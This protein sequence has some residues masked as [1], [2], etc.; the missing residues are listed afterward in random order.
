VQIAL[1][2]PVSLLDSGGQT[3]PL[4]GP[5]QRAVLAMLA[6]NVGH[7]VSVDRLIREIWQ[8][9]PPAAAAQGLQSYVS[10]LRRILSADAPGRVARSPASIRSRPPG[11]LLEMNADDIDAVRFTRLMTEGRALLTAQRPRAAHLRL[12]AALDLWRGPVLAD[13]DTSSFAVAE[14][15]R[16]EELRL[17]ALD[18]LLEVQLAL[19]DAVGC[20]STAR[21]VVQE[22]PY[23]ERAWKSLVLALYRDSRQAEALQT[24]SRMRELLADEL[25]IDP[26][27]ELA[28][29]HDQLLQQDPALQ[30]RPAPETD[31][32][33]AQPTD[34]VSARHQAESGIQL[35]LAP[36]ARAAPAT[37]LGRDREVD[38]LGVEAAH[39]ISGGT[40]TL[41]IQGAAGMGKSSLL[42]TLSNQV[43]D[44]GGRVARAAGAEGRAAPALWPWVMIARLLTDLGGPHSLELLAAPEGIPLSQLQLAGPTLDPSG[45]AGDP[46]LAR[47]LLFRAVID[48]VHAAALD[49]PLL[50]ALDDGHWLDEQSAQLLGLLVSEISAPRLLIA[51][52][53]RTEEIKAGTTL[54]QVLDTLTR[55]ATTV[56]RLKGL[57]V[58]DVAELT[59]NVSGGPCTPALAAAMAKRTDGNPL[60]VRE[61]SALLVSEQRLTEN[62][63]ASALPVGIQQIIRQRLDRLPVQTV[64]VLSAAAVLGPHIDLRVLGKMTSLDAESLLE[65]CETALLAGLLVEDSRSEGILALSHDL[66]RQTLYE[67]ISAPRRLRLHALAAEALGVLGRLRPETEVE[68]ARHLT[69]AAP[70]IGG[71][72]AV[73]ALLQVADDA[74]SKYAIDDVRHELGTALDLLKYIS[75]PAS[76]TRQ[77]VLIRTRLGTLAVLTQGLSHRSAAEQFEQVLDLAGTAPLDSMTN[78][79]WFGVSLAMWTRAEFDLPLRSAQAVLAAA[80]TDDETTVAAHYTCGMITFLLGRRQEAH[81]HFTGAYEL[82]ESGTDVGVLRTYAPLATFAGMLAIIC[83]QLED[84]HGCELWRGRMVGCATRDGSQYAL[85]MIPHMSAWLSVFRDDRAAAL[86]NA[87]AA[88]TL[89]AAHASPVNETFDRILR[90]WAVA[91]PG[92]PA[93]MDEAEDAFAEHQALGMQCAW[94]HLAALCAET[95][96]R[97]G[98]AERAITHAQR[99]RHA[100][101]NGQ[102]FLA[103]RLEHLVDDLL[104]AAQTPGQATPGQPGFST[105]K[106]PSSQPGAG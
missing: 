63:I 3:V 38:Q 21:G 54:A 39:L 76:R 56:L 17:S 29:L 18:D 55:G 62:G 101:D 47:T 30:W 70:I 28:R 71:E 64:S 52:A 51:V 6:L 57:R 10:R 90:A 58:R 14:T 102:A 27:P 99:S 31:D 26:S 33:V 84:P 68:I 72:H 61:L 35:R 105:G 11:W 77:E 103:I 80:T 34:Q 32:P 79:A 97:C 74:M 2:G 88:L 82:I 91:E 59:A 66:V 60:F 4:G 22:H 67:S 44:G 15:T 13:L 48:L 37:L 81:Q 83:H 78:T 98:D 65:A 8:D 100:A 89:L 23:R 73:A 49:G 40:G 1:L 86:S 25:G 50:I 9:E 41:L 92:N 93:A 69:I 43:R 5:R 85:L 46:E 104:Y 36:A 106:S 95:C 20:A 75:D 42:D 87:D 53:V 24:Y 94:A 96:L 12:R 45:D 16:L 19:G 7:V